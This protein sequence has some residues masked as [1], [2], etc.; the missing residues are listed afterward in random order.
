LRMKAMFEI[1]VR[2]LF[3]SILAASSRGPQA[4]VGRMKS[5]RGGQSNPL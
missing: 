1:S 3:E 4:V 5:A 2:L